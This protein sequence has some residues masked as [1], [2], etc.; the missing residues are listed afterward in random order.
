MQTNGFKAR[1]RCRG[2][3]KDESVIADTLLH[4]DFQADR[5]N[6]KWLADCTS[7]WTAGGWLYV[8]AVLDLFSRHIVGWSMKAERDVR[9]HREVLQSKAAPLETG[10]PQPNSVRGSRRATVTGRP[11]NRQQAN[12]RDLTFGGNLHARRR[13]RGEARQ[14]G[15]K[16]RRA[17]E[18][19]LAGLRRLRTAQ[20]R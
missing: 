3:P 5:P 11:R 18:P 16:R 14:G 4:R 8:A 9:L 19:C 13:P 10:L 12:K 2:L 7:I 17:A 15:C 20:N 1:A 6:Q